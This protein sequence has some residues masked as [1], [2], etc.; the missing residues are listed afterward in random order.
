MSNFVNAFYIQ[1]NETVLFNISIL[2]GFRITSS[3]F[4]QKE[5]EAQSGAAQTEYVHASA[6]NLK[7]LRRNGSRWRRN[8]ESQYFDIF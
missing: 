1:T 6:L 4:Y 3:A 7:S 2:Y 8:V 5:V